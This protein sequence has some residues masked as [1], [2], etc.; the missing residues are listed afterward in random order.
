M[1]RVL[2]VVNNSQRPIVSLCEYRDKILLS[3]RAADIVVDASRHADQ[4][5]MT[6]IMSEIKSRPLGSPT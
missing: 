4:T 3:E 1:M 5:T 6:T 2:Q